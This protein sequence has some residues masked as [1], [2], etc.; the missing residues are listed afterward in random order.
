MKQPA[1]T[2]SLYY[3]PNNKE[4]KA[5]VEKIVKWL[6]KRF[7]DTPIVKKD[8]QVLIVLGGDGT[9]LRAARKYHHTSNPLILG[10]N[11][12]QVGFLTSVRE[13][14][15]FLTCLDRFLKNKYRIIERMIFQTK[16]IRN[17]KEVFSTEALNEIVVQSLIGMVDISVKI[18]GNPIRE[19]RG[20]GALIST[21]TG[22]TA[23]NL[24]AHGPIVMPDIKCLIL[25]ELMDHNTPTP[26]IVIKYNKKVELKIKGFRKREI[27]SITK[28]KKKVD[29]LLIADGD[30]TFPLEKN[31]IIIIESSP[32]LIKFVEFEKNYFFKSLKEKFAFK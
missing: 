13:P 24:S 30:N 6:R 7:P 25:T 19:L 29:V 15:R 32:H 22:S 12:G 23:Y 16:V 8:P 5:W 27:L 31:D 10:L 18:E 2:L 3:R 14:R 11:L 1:T 9:I 17:R 21:A 4:A 26:S 20:S 28:S